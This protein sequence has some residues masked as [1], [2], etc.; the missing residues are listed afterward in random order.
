MLIESLSKP[1][2]LAGK[3]D[4]SLCFSVER[5]GSSSA[6]MS[7]PFQAFSSSHQVVLWS[8]V[9][10]LILLALARRWQ[11]GAA[12]LLERSLGLALILSWPLAAISHAR[13]GTLELGNALPLHF[14]DIA[15]VSGGIALWTRHRLACEIVYFFGLAGTLQGLLTPNLKVDYPDPRFF[16]F[17]ILHAGVVV[18][19][20][21]VVTS[22]RCPPRTG[23]VLR[24][25][26]VTMTYAATVGLI[27]AVLHT[28]YGFLC[29]K[30][31]QASLMDSL[32]VWP[33]YIA[34]MVLLCML[35]Y[36]LLNAPFAIARRW[37]DGKGDQA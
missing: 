31:E 11:V 4:A 34:S 3:P 15:A 14:C 29:H 33:W 28:N 25:F 19:A 8:T 7:A 2:S 37:S 6:A 10:L 35:L 20:L 23:A 30:P 18:A 16:A 17:F 21:H 13:F 22:L 27:N 24:M 26:G 1:S 9:G 12:V 32:G 5:S 36:T